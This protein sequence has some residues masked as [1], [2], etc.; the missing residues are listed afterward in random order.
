[1]K[2]KTLNEKEFK[3]NPKEKQ[4]NWYKSVSYI[5]K[6]KQ[7]LKRPLEGNGGHSRAW[8]HNIQEK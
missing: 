5:F 1:M 7:D 4:L 2:Q 6:I 8:R 3:K